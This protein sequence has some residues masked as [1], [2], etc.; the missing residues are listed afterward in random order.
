M[1]TRSV[2]FVL[3]LLTPVAAIRIRDDVPEDISTEPKSSEDTVTESAG[4]FE[5]A[6]TPEDFDAMSQDMNDMAEG[7][8]DQLQQIKRTQKRQREEARNSKKQKKNSALLQMEPTDKE[9]SSDDLSE[10]LQDDVASLP[11]DDLEKK[12]KSSEDTAAQSA[13][14]FE[15]AQTA[16]DFDRMSQDMNDMAQGLQGQLEQIKRTQKK[17]REEARDAKKRVPRK[18]RMRKHSNFL[19]LPWADQMGQ[20]KKQ[21][22][23]HA[24]AIQQQMKYMDMSTKEGKDFMKVALQNLAGLN[25]SLAPLS[26]A[27]QDQLQK[28]QDAVAQDGSDFAKS[29]KDFEDMHQSLKALTESLQA[30]SHQQAELDNKQLNDW[31]A[32]A[33]SQSASKP[34]KAA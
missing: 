11:E 3:L 15:D 14:D 17:Q 21:F 9:M 12:P 22:E 2:F 20:V 24:K 34:K 5:K 4:D 30:Q 26:D 25:D 8:Q 27:M 1:A 13:G 16:E 6:E 10:E 7:L 31:A 29:A 18:G 19:K 32:W 28:Q 23:E 33:K